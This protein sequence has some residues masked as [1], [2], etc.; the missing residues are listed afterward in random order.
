MRVSDKIVVRKLFET[1][2]IRRPLYVS[3]CSESVKESM[4]ICL[5]HTN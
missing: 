3:L 1:L 2:A 5:I 4:D